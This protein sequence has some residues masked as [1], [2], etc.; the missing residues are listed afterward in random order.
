[1]N[2]ECEQ[3]ITSGNSFGQWWQLNSPTSDIQMLV[4]CK[5]S[6]FS[7]LVHINHLWKGNQ[8][9]QIEV[10]LSFK[11]W[12]KIKVKSTWKH[13][14]WFWKLTLVWMIWSQVPKI[15]IIGLWYSFWCKSGMPS[16]TFK[17]FGQIDL[18]WFRVSICKWELPGGMQNK[19]VLKVSEKNFSWLE[20]HW[21]TI[22]VLP[23]K[24]KLRIL[25]RLL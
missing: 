23:K 5:L 13:K 3:Y 2:L 25:S 10:K 22:N 4:S 24:A 9:M 6:Y 15:M 11:F 18:S 14:K 1:M 19:T 7:Q 12:S 17:V 20:S 16:K 8:I 21:K